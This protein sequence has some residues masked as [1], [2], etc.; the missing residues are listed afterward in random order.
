MIKVG[1]ASEEII[2]AARERDVSLIALSR[3]GR[4]IIDE[5]VIGSTADPVVR[6]ATRPVLLLKG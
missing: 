5:L 6:R 3:R 2:K 4:G 1:I